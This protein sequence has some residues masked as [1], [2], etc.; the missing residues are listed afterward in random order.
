[1]RRRKRIQ[2]VIAVAV[3]VAGVIFCVGQVPAQTLAQVGNGAA[4][5]AVGMAQPDKSAQHLGAQLEASLTPPTTAPTV[6][7]PTTPPTT[8][9]AVQ[10]VGPTKPLTIPEKLTGAGTVSEQKVSVGSDF[11]KGVAVRNRSGKVFD[12][13]KEIAA[14]TAPQLEKNTKDPQVLIVHTHTTEGYLTYDTGF[15]NP[16]DVE[17]TFDR[18]RNICAAGK[19]I[20]D[21]LRAAGI[22]VVHDTTVH[23]NPQYTGAYT[24][25]EQTV[26]AL[27]KKYPSI[28]V[29]LDI[30]RDAILPD[31]T[32][33]VKPTVTVNGK[34]AAQMMIIAGVV[35]TESLP[36]P[37]WQKN[38]H[39]ALRLQ[40]SLATTYPDLMRPLYLVASRYNQHLSA[41]YLLVE[42]G[43]D[44]NT[45]DEA[46]YA[47]ELLGNILANLS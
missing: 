3:T 28:Q 8:A 20:A 11:V 5:L 26:T 25:S 23:D 34:K 38:F 15:Y 45:V 18:T 41:G 33:H 4:L 16:A 47:G 13:A 42:I 29:V 39:F 44:V 9:D 36:H 24:R 40:Q 10:V 14:A 12:L 17:R 35:S 43:S 27:L 32:T 19:A 37:N 31:N 7:R 2:R 30:H 21:T 46:V 6:T 22:A 1:M